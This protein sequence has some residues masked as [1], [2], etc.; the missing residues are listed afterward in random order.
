MEN[1]EN[2][3]IFI[4]DIYFFVQKE[5]NREMKWFVVKYE[6]KIGDSGQFILFL[7]SLFL[8]LKRIFQ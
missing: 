4:I 7:L 1:Q 6:N 5:K 2:T 3:N 8:L